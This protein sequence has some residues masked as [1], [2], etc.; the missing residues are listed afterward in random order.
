MSVRVRKCS[1]VRVARNAGVNSSN[2]V[3]KSI[4]SVSVNDIAVRCKK[5][6]YIYIFYLFLSRGK[7]PMQFRWGPGT[8]RRRGAPLGTPYSRL[9]S[10]FEKQKLKKK[11]NRGIIIIA[12]RIH[13]DYRNF[14]NRLIGKNGKRKKGHDEKARHPPG[15]RT[16]TTTAAAAMDRAT[17]DCKTRWRT[18]YFCVHVRKSA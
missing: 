8:N 1:V 11:K 6:K 16:H 7:N 14:N 13:R 10:G 18:R 9:P 5:K 12:L 4:R 15:R 2:K 17:E 3:G